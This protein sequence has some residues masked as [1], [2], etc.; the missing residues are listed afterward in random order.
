MKKVKA[1]LLHPITISIFGITLL[2]LLVWF[3]GPH[4]KFGA[5][6]VAPLGEPTVRLL[7]IMAILVL[8]GLN[9]LRIQAKAR[10]H[11]KELVDDIR[12]RH[13]DVGRDHTSDKAAEEVAPINERFV[14]PL[15]TLRKLRFN[16]RANRKRKAL[17]ELPWYILVGPPGAGNPTAFVN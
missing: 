7:I 10:K 15:N 6:N 5:D 17:Y 13:D 16:G 14:A 1:V 4:I 11:N 3:F 8:W 2:S 12:Q 9:N